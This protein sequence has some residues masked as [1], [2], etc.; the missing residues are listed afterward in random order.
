MALCTNRRGRTPITGD[1]VR[2][3]RGLCLHRQRSFIF[4]LFGSLGEPELGQI[5]YK[6]SN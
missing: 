1:E 2:Y 5:V 6:T 3:R 4:A